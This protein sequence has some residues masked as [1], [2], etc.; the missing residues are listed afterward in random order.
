MAGPGRPLGHGADDPLPAP[1]LPPPPAGR[2]APPRRPDVPRE[3]WSGA[4]ASPAARLGASLLVLAV[5]TA[6]L[7]GGLLAIRRVT[8]PDPAS[9]EHRFL[10]RRV[11]GSPLRWNACD[12]IHYVVN[13]TRAPAGSVA[14]VHEAIRRVSEATG[15]AFAYDGLTD[16]VPTKDRAPFQ[17]ERYGARWAP[18]LIAWVAPEETDIPFRLEGH[19][20]AAVASPLRPPSGEEVFVSGYVA[21]NVRDP[22]PPGFGAPGDQGPVLLHELGH[23]MGLGHVDRPGAIMEPSGGGVTDFGPGD[24][25]GL[26]RVGREAG[27]VVA[28]PAPAGLAAP[29]P[30]G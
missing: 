30:A 4:Q 29:R 5:A 14:D 18:V 15:I 11:D 27:C 8:A 9:L 2:P 20:A 22:N 23:V 16:E 12:T 10:D 25:E 17:P 21:M 6:A 3:R 19:T 13:A 1:P 7:G 24:L 28:P 26:R